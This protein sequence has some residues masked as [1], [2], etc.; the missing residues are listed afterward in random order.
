MTKAKKEC[1]F[2]HCRVN[3]QLHPA[4]IFRPV[5]P[6]VKKFLRPRMLITK[7]M[8]H[9]YLTV[10]AF[11]ELDSAD[12]TLMCAIFGIAKSE[13]MGEYVW[14]EPKN[15][16]ILNPLEIMLEGKFII[17]KSGKKVAEYDCMQAPA[18]RI[19]TTYQLLK[20]CGKDDGG[21][22]RKWLLGTKGRSGAL[23]R[24]STVNFTYKGDKWR[25]S[26]NLMSWTEDIETEEI[27]ITINPA[28]ALTIGFKT[29]HIYTNLN[30]R[31]Q[32][33]ERAKILHF[34]LCGLIRE[35]GKR[36]IK[37]DTFGR[38]LW[39][40]NEADKNENTTETI[41]DKN[42]RRLIKNSLNEIGMLDNWTVS[43]T[44]I[45]TRTLA[46]IQRTPLP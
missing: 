4:D 10:K 17:L 40:T 3:P 2:P 38:Y 23:D 32:L 26:F 28:S 11:E 33:S 29:P 12:Q 15:E 21:T 37:V 27:L 9:G 20:E 14:I 36:S 41:V 31:L 7:E 6:G 25:G 44:G 46:N 13:Q 19:R 45:G 35:G 8:A 43:F 5:Q 30:E 42:K 34:R 39:W 1:R 24:L 16:N 22:Q 18:I